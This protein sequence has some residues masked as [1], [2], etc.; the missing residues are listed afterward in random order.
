MANYNFSNI[1]AVFF[2]WDN[3]LVDAWPVLL[4]ATNA[5]RQQFSLEKVSLEQLKILARQSTR[6]GFPQTYGKN[7]QQ[8][9]KNFYEQIHLNADLLTIFPQ[10]RDLLESLKV[11]NIKTALISNKLNS[12]LH[13]EVQSMFLNFDI[14]LGSGDANA[15]K[16]NPEMGIIAM[17]NLGLKSSDVIYVGDSVTDWIFAKNLNMPAIAIG[18]DEFNGPLVA[19]FATPEKAFD[20]LIENLQS[21]QA[22][23]KIAKCS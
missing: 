11:M 7:W 21:T 16:P 12:L 23:A 13:Q 6:E 17:N 4:A 15:D 5:T 3:T 1:K 18:D 9:Q 2:D 14:V 20:F 19:R 22:V 10:T 8:A